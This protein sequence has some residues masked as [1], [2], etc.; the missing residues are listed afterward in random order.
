V[1]PETIRELHDRLV[2]MAQ[3]RNV[4]RGRKLRV[5]TTVVESNIHYRMSSQGWRIQR[6]TTP[7]GEESEPCSL[8]GREEGNRI[9]KVHRQS[10]PWGGERV[11]G[12]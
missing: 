3:E 9:R 5:D 10:R 1:G 7:P 12:P 4:I 11:I 6:E 8:D 2:A